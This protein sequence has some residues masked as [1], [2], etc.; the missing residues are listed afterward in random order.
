MELQTREK[1]IFALIRKNGQT[2]TELLESAKTNR[3]SLSRSIK[4]LKDNEKLIKKDQDNLYHFTTNLRNSVLRS[5][6][7]VYTMTKD[8]DVFID[9]IKK[10]N[11]PFDKTKEMINGIL[12]IQ[13]RLKIERYSAKKL[14]RRDKLEFDLLSDVFDASIELIFE[15]LYMKNE[16]QTKK[17]KKSLIDGLFA[18]QDK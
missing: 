15:M 16:N 4:I 6:P 18:K 2:F 8:L 14:T 11:N 7:G 1:V 5:L 12:G 9:F 13:L 17:M 3:D 10:D